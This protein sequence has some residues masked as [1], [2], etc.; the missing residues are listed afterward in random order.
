MTDA[1]T[2]SVVTLLLLLGCV[3]TTKAQNNNRLLTED[4]WIGALTWTL[5]TL[6]F[7]GISTASM[8]VGWQV[9]TRREEQKRW[10][11]GIISLSL[12]TLIAVGL[13]IAGITIGWA[14]LQTP[15]ESKN[16]QDVYSSMLALYLATYGFLVIF[17]IALFN[18]YSLAWG[19]I[20]WLLALASSAAT[21]GLMW[22]ISRVAFGIFFAL[23][24]WIL[25]IGIVLFWAHK[26]NAAKA[27]REVIYVDS[28][29]HHHHS[30]GHTSSSSSQKHSFVVEEPIK[31]N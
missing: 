10:M 20:F 22:R 30:H 31:W 16:A 25:I 23:P 1:K 7:L 28:E 15:E 11:T 6:F 17:S 14:N 5:V 18:M 27:D 4:K 8:V 26:R 3:A 21:L 13:G 29:S 24:V 9:W 19:V 12:L 2:L